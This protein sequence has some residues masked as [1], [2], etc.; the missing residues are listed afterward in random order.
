[1]SMTEAK[2]NPKLGPV[3]SRT[4]ISVFPWTL[5]TVVP[6]SLYQ[7]ERVTKAYM[8]FNLNVLFGVWT[9]NACNF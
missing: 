6:T 4:E 9:D 3:S 7:K 5:L 8:D 1:M 2:R